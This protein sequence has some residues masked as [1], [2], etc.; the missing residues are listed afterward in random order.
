MQIPVHADSQPAPGSAHAKHTPRIPPGRTVP[1]L[2]ASMVAQGAAVHAADMETSNQLHKNCL[3]GI[4]GSVMDNSA[5][6]STPPDTVAAGATKAS[7]EKTPHVQDVA[8]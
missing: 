7:V 5:D 4:G 1:P 2:D 8:P 3:C 6:P